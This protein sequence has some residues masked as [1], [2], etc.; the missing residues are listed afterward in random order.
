[1]VRPFRT[2]RVV[3]LALGFTAT[4]GACGGGSS[5]GK[6]GSQN[7]APAITAPTGPGI[8]WGIDPTYTTV[9]NP[10]DSLDFSVIA[11]DADAANTLTFTASVTGGSLTE[12]Q[13]GFT[14]FPSMTTG[15]S[16]QSL[17]FAGT[18]AQVGNIE[19]TFL[20]DDGEGAMDTVSHSVEVRAGTV[21]AWGDNMFGQLG[22]GTTTTSLIPV[23]VVDPSDPTSFLTGVTAVATGWRHTVA[24]LGDG[25]F[26][27]WGDNRFG[28]LGDGTTTDSSTPVQ[29]VDPSDPTGFLT[30]VIAVDGGW[31]HTVA[32]LGDGTVRAWGSNIL[33]QLGDGTTTDISTPVQVV[34]PSDPTGFLTGVTAGAVGNFHT[35]ALLDDATVLT[36]GD[37]LRGQLG[38]GTTTDSSTPVQVVDPSDPTGFLT[39]V[40]ALAAG[41]WHTVA[42]LGD[43]TVRAWG[44]NIL[45]QL[46]DG[47]TTNSSTPVQVVDPSDP[48]GSLTGVTAVA[49]GTRHTVALLGDG[50]V[51]VWGWHRFGQLGDGTTTDSSTPVQVVDPSDPTSFLTGVTAVAAVNH[52]TVALLG[53][54]T[55]RAWGYNLS[56][57]L[58]D[59]TTTDSS[60]PV[61]VIDPSDP[62]GFLTGVT[63]LAAGWFH[64]VALH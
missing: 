26:R 28:Q 42:L 25:T 11:T 4:V 48:T 47:T 53:D 10:G 35:V 57:Q 34:D 17:S 37:N 9:I 51:R 5:G 24:L 14:S 7:V 40:T 56:G 32:L 33:G 15:A 12:A 22:D 62:S 20:V 49:A 27:A 8:V 30:G 1:M 46:G 54:G 60:T 13:T 59:G 36:W 18:A 16:P 41:W 45:G 61:Q 43:G 63:A 21:Q 52:H 19:I 38:D 39:G 31:G 29:V 6:T 58:G 55:L 50:P 23:E 2:A 44:S 64:T 3:L